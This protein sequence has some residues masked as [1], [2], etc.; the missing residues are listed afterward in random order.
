MLGACTSTGNKIK[1]DLKHDQPSRHE[2]IPTPIPMGVMGTIGISIELVVVEAA[3]QPQR[4][5]TFSST[6]A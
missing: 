6:M 1:N 4:C 2:P 5:Q 3:R